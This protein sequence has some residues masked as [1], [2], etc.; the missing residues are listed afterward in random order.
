MIDEKKINI[1]FGNKKNSNKKMFIPK[2]LNKSYVV[3]LG[4]VTLFI[5]MVIYIFNLEDTTKNNSDVNN[6]SE[7][8]NQ[9]D[10]RKI[11]AVQTNTQ[12]LPT[13][14]QQ[15]QQSNENQFDMRKIEAAQNTE[16]AKVE[17]AQAEILKRD[18]TENSLKVADLKALEDENI[19]LKNEI[20]NL[21]NEIID[22]K[23]QKS[24]SKTK[25]INTIDTNKI[26]DDMESYLTSIKKNIKRRGDNF[27]FEQ[28]NYYIGD[29]LKTYQ[30]RDIQKN[31]IRFCNDDDL[32]YTL[33]F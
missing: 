20:E 4:I 11:E 6:K 14:I 27:N 21:K 15:F 30:V 24:L 3:V 1:D 26:N 12:A 8:T 17:K 25:T 9:F 23:A 32:C 16:L 7:V 28:K 10:M 22:L 19:E 31:K 18:E 33:I 13:P 5:L 29:K 2:K